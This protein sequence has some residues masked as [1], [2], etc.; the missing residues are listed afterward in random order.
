MITV[1]RA[2]VNDVDVLHRLGEGVSEFSVSDQT[3]TFWPK[4]ILAQAIGAHDVVIL[5]AEAGQQVVGFIIANLNRSLR[6]ATIENVYVR[7]ENRGAGIAGK[8]LAELLTSIKSGG[9]EY[10]NTLIPLDADDASGLYVRTGFIKGE[11]FL[12]LDMSLADTFSK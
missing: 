1:R 10:V 7:P 4:D 8:L 5:V 2:E 3:V 6:K 11:P 12:W 9:I